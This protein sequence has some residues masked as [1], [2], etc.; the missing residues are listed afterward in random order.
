MVEINIEQFEGYDKD[1]FKEFLLTQN[2]DEYKLVL[3]KETVL[4]FS[5]SND[6]AWEYGSAA[7]VGQRIKELSSNFEYSSAPLA[8]RGEFSFRFKTNKVDELAVLLLYIS[9]GYG[10]IEIIE[11]IDF[12]CEA[13]DFIET[14]KDNRDIACQDLIDV[15][16]E[17][18]VAEEE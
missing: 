2:E 9:S 4:F 3:P 14:S 15:Y 11:P 7:F 8:D 10:N 12:Q 6:L 5:E 13:S 16:F 17:Y 1:E 18:F